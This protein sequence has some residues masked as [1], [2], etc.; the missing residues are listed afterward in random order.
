MARK[1]VLLCPCDTQKQQGEHGVYN[2][3]KGF[4]T[5]GLFRPVG[6][7]LVRS[8]TSLNLIITSCEVGL[9]LEPAASHGEGKE[10]RRRPRERAPGTLKRL[11][12]PPVP[13]TVEWLVLKS[14]LCRI[15]L[16]TLDKTFKED[17]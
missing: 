7:P 1:G 2:Q 17:D 12:G 13:E 9:L 10:G 15:Q 16:N 4:K 6:C 11:P 3:P 14:T 8:L 5:Q